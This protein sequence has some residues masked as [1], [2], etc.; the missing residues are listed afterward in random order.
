[1]EAKNENT[2]PPIADQVKEYI[3]TRIKLAK[4]QAIEGGSKVAAS[5]IADAVIIISMVLAFFFAS[6]TLAYFLGSLFG[7]EW[8]GFG[9]VALLYFAI[10]MVIRYNRESI[11]KRLANSFVQNIFSNEDE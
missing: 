3:E 10:A 7:A 1:M 4:Y 8:I 9:C 11:K 5:V 2:T 6:F